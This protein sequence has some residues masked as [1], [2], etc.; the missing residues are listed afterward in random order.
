MNLEQHLIKKCQT[1]DRDRIHVIYFSYHSNFRNFYHS[2]LLLGTK[3][4]GWIKGRESTDHI[5]HISRFNY[6]EEK[7]IYR[8]KIFEANTKRGMEENDFIQRLKDFDGRLYIQTL[9]KV[10]KKLARGFENDYRGVPYEKDSALFA[11]IDIP[12]LDRVFS[13]GRGRGFC[14]W[15]EAIFLTQQG[16]KIKAESGNPSEL[17]PEDIKNENLAPTILFYDSN[18]IY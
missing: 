14:S 17:T 8:P 9:G 16:Y 5:C 2:P 12:I 10:D 4:L 7:G 6:D 18:E 11:G 15:L 1:L 3:I 13:K